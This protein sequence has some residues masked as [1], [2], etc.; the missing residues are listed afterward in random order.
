MHRGSAEIWTLR[1]EAYIL[2][3]V[4][5]IGWHRSE[6]AICQSRPLGK[7]N[8]SLLVKRLRPHAHLS[9]SII[10]QLLRGKSRTIPFQ[11]SRSSFL[12]ANANASATKII[13]SG[14]HLSGIGQMLHSNDI[15]QTEEALRTN[16]SYYSSI[17]LVSG[18][19]V[20]HKTQRL[21]LHP[22]HDFQGM[23]FG[24]GLAIRSNHFYYDDLLGTI[25]FRWVST[26]DSGNGL[27]ICRDLLARSYSRCPS[28][29][30]SRIGRTI[31]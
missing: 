22:L 13:R 26:R 11:P 7:R 30:S 5:V 28:C 31:Y 29:E 17:N 24:K 15:S 27:P 4:E 19:T 12:D 18:H 10:P 23:P 16:G 25:P 14:P 21:C 6:P 1:Q 2:L 8:Q 9:I 3:L 20:S